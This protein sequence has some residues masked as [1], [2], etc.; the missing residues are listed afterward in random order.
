V[1]KDEV[2]YIVDYSLDPKVMQRLLD[3]TANVVWIDHHKSAIES[4]ADFPED[5]AGVRDTGDAACVLTWKYLFP[6]VDT[7]RAVLWVGDK[8]TWKWE[9]GEDTADFCNGAAC[10]DTS[11]MEGFWSSVVDDE[12]AL[13]YVNMCG[14]VVGDYKRQFYR[15]MLDSIG[16]EA[17][18]DG[19]KCLVLNAAR[20]NS[21]AFGERVEDYPFVVAFYY[22]GEQYHFSLYSTKVDVSEVAKKHGGGGHPGASGFQS[23]TLPFKV[24]Q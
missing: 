14:Q 5:I 19:E 15:E 8:D 4:Y 3:K 23:T 12:D 11:P 6:G 16:F 13:M 10:Y 22:D 24:K 9:F 21:E 1:D 18:L 2:V 17:T 7:P 20:V